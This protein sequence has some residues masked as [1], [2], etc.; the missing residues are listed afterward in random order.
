MKQ[1]KEEV[2]RQNFTLSV[3]LCVFTGNEVAFHSQFYHERFLIPRLVFNQTGVGH[4]CRVLILSTAS[5]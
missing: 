1:K 5:P 3:D 4:G 2:E